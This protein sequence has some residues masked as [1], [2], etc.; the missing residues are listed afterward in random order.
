MEACHPFIEADIAPF[1]ELAGREGWISGRWEF[2][3]LLHSF[4]E[5]CFTFREN[6]STLAYITSVKYGRR[7][8]GTTTLPSFCW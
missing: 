8:S 1:L 3:F 6:G 4:P 2:E 7:A 5:G